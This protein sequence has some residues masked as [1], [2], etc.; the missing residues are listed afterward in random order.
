MTV[1]DDM[2]TKRGSMQVTQTI[3]K[4]SVDLQLK[5]ADNRFLQDELE[6]KEKMLSLLTEGLKE[7]EINQGKGR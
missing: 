5:D 4:L 6:K 1:D 7:V 2:M 3:E